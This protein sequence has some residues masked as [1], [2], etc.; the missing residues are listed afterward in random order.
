MIK[1]FAVIAVVSIINKI[2]ILQVFYVQIHFA[3]TAMVAQAF[4]VV[5][6]VQW[7]SSKPRFLNQVLFTF[8]V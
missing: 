3:A 1:L 8:C 2:I 6:G 5:V 4:D 7:C